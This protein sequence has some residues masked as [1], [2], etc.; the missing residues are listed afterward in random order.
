MIKADVMSNPA[1]YIKFINTLNSGDYN[2]NDLKSF[3]DSLS[4]KVKGI[5]INDTTPIRAND[6][7]CVGDRRLAYV[8]AGI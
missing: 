8:G 4:T 5:I 3:F 6:L 7:W 1:L 2:A